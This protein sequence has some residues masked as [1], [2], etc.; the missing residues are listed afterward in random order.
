[1][2]HNYTSLLMSGNLTYNSKYT[3]LL[4]MR[5]FDYLKGR[6]EKKLQKERMILCLDGGGM[7]GIVPA[8]V[9]AHLEQLFLKLGDSRPLYSHFDLIAGTS[10][11]GLIALALTVPTNNEL[12]EQDKNGSTISRLAEIY[13]NYGTT[14][15]PKNNSII[16]THVLNQLF[17]YK[18]ED[19]S[20]NTLLFDLFG[21]RRLSEALTPTIVTAYDYK[22]DAPFIFSSIR[23]PQ[24][25]ARAAARATS[26]APTFFSPAVMKNETD[27]DSSLL[28]DGGV[29]ANNPVLYAYKEARALYPETEKFHI[30]SLGTGK[31][32]NRQT[33]ENTNSG[34]L[35][36]F[37]PTKG[38]PPLYRLYASA[39]MNTADQIA[40]ILP[41]VE[42][43]RIH[44][45][46]PRRVRM[47]ETDPLILSELVEYADQ[48][49][50]ENEEA[51]TA[52][53]RKCVG[54]ERRPE[55]PRG[56]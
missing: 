53:C 54:K 26:A 12:L 7:R 14:I 9:L 1:M 43:L 55:R 18:Y 33:G 24:I 6:Q 37:D 11:G 35:G 23:T 46:F 56:N 40:A 13:K 22:K 8:T 31:S 44:K 42:Y 15:F 3:M 39:Q 28:I 25:P 49:F 30:L 45:D 34:V 29:V 2:I 38:T 27:N 50:K 21:E 41:D 32:S 19:R 47:D 36:W 51:L 4:Y 17:S 48:V 10:T 5:L 20:F 16:P 52:F